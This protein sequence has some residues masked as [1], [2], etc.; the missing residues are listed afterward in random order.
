MA[1]LAPTTVPYSALVCSWPRSHPLVE[2]V[3]LLSKGPPSPATR[4]I[5]VL[6]LVALSARASNRRA[7]WANSTAAGRNWTLGGCPAQESAVVPALRA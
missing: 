3:R 2:R 6:A 1:L 7:D 5:G 4:G